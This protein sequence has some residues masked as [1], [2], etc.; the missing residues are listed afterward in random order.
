MIDIF[1]TDHYYSCDTFNEVDPKSMDHSYLRA[2]SAAVHQSI[3]QED[4]IGIWVMQAWLFHSGYWNN[5]PSL[6]EAYLSGV[7][8]ESMLI[9]D[10]NSEDGVLATKYHQYYGK[11]WVWNMLHNYGGVR[12]VYGNLTTIATSPYDSLYTPGGTMIGLGFTPEAIE[13]NPVMY[14]MLTSTFWSSTPI[15]VQSWLQA[16]V[17][18]RYGAESPLMWSA[19]QLLFHA[20]YNQPGEPRSEIEWVPHWEQGSFGWQN[21]DA[22]LMYQAA[23]AFLEAVHTFPNAEANG[24]L[25]YD[26]VDIVRQATTMFFSDLHR[27][28]SNQ[29]SIAQSRTENVTSSLAA[30]GALQL[31]LISSLDLLFSTNP[32]YLLGVWTTRA[33][34][35][36]LSNETLLYLYNAKNQITLWG[37]DAQICDYAA[38]AWSGL[39][40]SYY[41]RRWEAMI[42]SL[43]AFSEGTSTYWNSYQFEQQLL[44]VEKQWCSNGTAFPSAPTAGLSPIAIAQQLID[45]IHVSQS[46]VTS[47]YQVLANMDGLYNDYV[48]TP[49]RGHNVEQ[50]ALLCNLVDDCAGFTAS[51]YL[52]RSIRLMNNTGSTLYVKQ[53]SLKRSL[54]NHLHQPRSINWRDSIEEA[55]SIRSRALKAQQERE[56]QAGAPRNPREARMRRIPGHRSFPFN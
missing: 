18:Q 55:V 4:P 29:G 40:S 38:K 51:G 11:P 10:L 24:P 39:Y 13:Q 8:N 12:G 27:Q 44:A 48:F 49:T 34:N 45:K 15:D 35:L 3:V 36:G 32:N 56:R 42:Q 25:M 6:V 28:L 22:T 16:Y 53:R 1:G 7:S 19:W 37:P 21:G 9:L 26:L 41:H 31:D 20:V 47:D 14:E 54:E 33:T 23:V 52:K 2:A 5:N 50:L 30:I 43:L 46:V 17:R